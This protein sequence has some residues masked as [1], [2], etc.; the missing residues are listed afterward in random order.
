MQ[1][2]ALSASTARR[3]DSLSHSDSNSSLSKKA[4]NNRLQP[5]IKPSKTAQDSLILKD[6]LPTINGSPSSQAFPTSTDRANQVERLLSSGSTTPPLPPKS[7]TPTKIP[8][9]Y[10]RSSVTSPRLPASSIRSYASSVEL[11]G[12]PAVPASSTK[13]SR[14]SSTYGPSQPLD[15][16]SSMN[17]PSVSDGDF[18]VNREPGLAPGERTLSTRRRLDADTSGIPRS[19]SNAGSSLSS[20]RTYRDLGDVVS[21][22]DSRAGT[23][24]PRTHRRTSLLS[25]EDSRNTSANQTPRAVALANQMKSAL[26]ESTS[27]IASASVRRALSKPADTSRASEVAA[28]RRAS[29]APESSMP[30]STT[31]RILPSKMAIPSRVS[32]FSATSASPADARR[33]REST[34]SPAYDEEAKGDEEMAAYVRRQHTKKMAAGISA[35]TIKKMFEFPDPTQPLPALNSRGQSLSLT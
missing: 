31:S 24:I 6:S 19:R 35:D 18:A 10:G 8:R 25:S 16:S 23:A 32:P 34:K 5:P 30:L 21:P 11:D 28:I 33:S 9:L 4:V 29:V 26:S 3:V 17:F 1:M 27:S 7:Q 12:P 2:S 15:L 20:S 14:R 22:P 13:P